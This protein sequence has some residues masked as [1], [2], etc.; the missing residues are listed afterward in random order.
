[1][2]HNPE[3]RVHVHR[4]FDTLDPHTAEGVEAH[5]LAD[6]WVQTLPQGE[7]EDVVVAVRSLDPALAEQ[8]LHSAFGIAKPAP[9][10]EG[11]EQ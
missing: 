9:I 4:L 10:I 7:R 11:K 2:W 1:M 5:V 8:R 6:P 3:W